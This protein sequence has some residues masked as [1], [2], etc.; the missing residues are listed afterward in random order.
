MRREPVEVPEHVTHL[1]DEMLFELT[2]QRLE[3]CL[4]P[5]PYGGEYRM[6]RAVC[7]MNP[8]WYRDLCQKFPCTRIKARSKKKDYTKIKR[9]N[10]I[11]VLTVMVREKK[12][13]SKYAEDL[14]QVAMDR[15]IVFQQLEKLETEF[16]FEP[17]N[18][19]F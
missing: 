8:D 7:S 6:V 17:W 10:I 4:I 12:S 15:Y 5:A 14:I 11:S 19:Q 18:N 2:E 3:V 16:R 1:L 13:Y 9:T